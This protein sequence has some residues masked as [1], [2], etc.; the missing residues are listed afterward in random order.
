MP[1]IEQLMRLSGL[2]AL[3]FRP[4][5]NFVNVGERTNITGSK[6]LLD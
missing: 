5:L 6:N 3:N 2:E 4:D 1:A